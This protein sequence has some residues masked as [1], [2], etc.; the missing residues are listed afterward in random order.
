MLV[1]VVV[2]IYCFKRRGDNGFMEVHILSCE[3]GYQQFSAHVVTHLAILAD[4]TTKWT[5]RVGA[6]GRIFC[7]NKL[8][9]INLGTPRMW[10]CCSIR[11]CSFDIT[12]PT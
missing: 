1:L 4:D 6:G 8:I 2:M 5:F 3:S 11:P 10:L 9:T 7:I 12:G